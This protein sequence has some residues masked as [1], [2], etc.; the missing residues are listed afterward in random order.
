MDAGRDGVLRRSTIV[1]DGQERVEL[2]VFALMPAILVKKAPYL[3]SVKQPLSWLV[4]CDITYSD[5]LDQ[6]KAT[7]PHDLRF[8]YEVQ[9]QPTGRQVVT[10]GVGAIASSFQKLRTPSLTG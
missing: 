2:P 8:C 7:A 3:G 9:A 4:V 6:P 5:E 1:P 10:C